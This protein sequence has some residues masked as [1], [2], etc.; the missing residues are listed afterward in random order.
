MVAD[1]T[2]SLLP[3]IER[4]GLG[5]AAEIEVDTLAAR[6]HAAVTSAGASARSPDLV[7]AWCTPPNG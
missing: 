3:V 7:A 1:V 4:A 2:R 5:T 6:L